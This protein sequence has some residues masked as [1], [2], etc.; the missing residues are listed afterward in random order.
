MV[1]RVYFEST[2][3]RSVSISGLMTMRVRPAS[4]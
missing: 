2:L 1:H 3:E 4:C